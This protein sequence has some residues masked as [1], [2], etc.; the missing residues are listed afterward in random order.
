M[1]DKKALNISTLREQLDEILWLL[2]II[3]PKPAVVDY[4]HATDQILAL[5]KDSIEEAMPEKREVRLLGGTNASAVPYENDKAALNDGF[6]Q[7]IK[8][9]REAWRG[10][11]E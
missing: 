8:E 11:D 4:E 5:L 10:V 7:A 1:S 9:I 6:N 3:K 2:S